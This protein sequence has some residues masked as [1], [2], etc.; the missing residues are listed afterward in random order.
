MGQLSG[1][2]PNACKSF[3][4]SG[5][6]SEASSRS[7]GARDRS[8]P[9]RLHDRGSGAEAG[10]SEYAR[11]KHGI[12]RDQLKRHTRA[13]RK[14]F[15]RSLTNPAGSSDFTSSTANVRDTQ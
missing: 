11:T 5:H 2:A 15:N 6:R 1:H 10:G 9:R 13:N 8:Q 12:D 7:T 3:T 14:P 4:E